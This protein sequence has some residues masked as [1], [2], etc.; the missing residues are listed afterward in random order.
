MIRKAVIPAAGF[1]TRFLPAT[2]AQPKEM[3]P[4]VDTPVI[5]LVV[6]EAVA[7]GITDIVIVTG[8]GKRAIENHFDRS[9]DLEVRL[10][11]K[12]DQAGYDLVRQSADLASIHFIR[13]PDP[14]G[15]GD[16]VFCARHH[17]G[18]EPFAVLLG[19]TIVTG[20]EPATGQL[21]AL[22]SAT[23]RSVIGVETA[24]EEALERYG[25]IGGEPTGDG[26]FT[27][28]RIV[29]KPAPGEA[30][31]RLAVAGRYILTPTVFDILADLPPGRGDEIQLSDAL[32]RLIETEGVSARIID[33]QRFDIG[34]KLDF[35]LTNLIFALGREELGAVLRTRLPGILAGSE[36][37]QTSDSTPADS[38]A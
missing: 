37:A 19:D 26:T 35:V 18:N 33:G 28:H 22:Y 1:G 7:A 15:L 30:P 10:R 23:G 9:P 16:A 8:R 13:Q 12:G 3:L 31:S 5:Q 21:A 2:K 4:I 25:V 29:E 34:S 11:E 38:P 17:I 32:A 24:A 20:R 14:R 6:E 27:V 36:G